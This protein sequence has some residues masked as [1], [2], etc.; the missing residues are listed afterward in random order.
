MAI[1]WV[2]SQVFRGSSATRGVRDRR[3]SRVV[4]RG[5]LRGLDDTVASYN[6]ALNFCQLNWASFDPIEGLPRQT[7]SVVKLSGDKAWVEATYGL[8][9]GIDIDNLNAMAR[10]DC[11]P[12]V[13]PATWYSTHNT[14][15]ATNYAS[16]SWADPVNH[17]PVKHDVLTWRFV[18][19]MVYGSTPLTAA[20]RAMRNRIN[21]ASFSLGGI[22][23]PQHTVRFDGPTMTARRLGAYTLYTTDWWFTVREDGWWEE[24]PANNGTEIT[25][26]L[27]YDTAAFSIETGWTP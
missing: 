21:A 1:S 4:R 10:A 11:K 15:N 3:R 5:V 26:R 13:H 12:T 9:R 22:T 14:Y 19:H 18:A 17:N 6:A 7:I 16:T 23:W 27:M 20:V 2:E 8:T 24:R 25:A